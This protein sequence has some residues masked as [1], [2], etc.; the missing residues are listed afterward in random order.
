MTEPELNPTAA[1]MAFLLGTW[2]GQGKGDYPTIQPFDYSEE[3]AI[4][5]NGKPYLIYSHKTIHLGTGLPAHHEMGYFRPVADDRVE[6]VVVMPT[7][8]TEIEA[9]TL[10]GTTIEMSST[11]VGRAPT[12]KDVTKLE[13]TFT[14]DGDVMRYEV[15][16]A[17]VGQ[18]LQRHLIAELRRAD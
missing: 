2:R 10:D 5:H 13:R 9:G 8:I 18:P 7:G 17:A 6:L 11:G 14:V 12:A 15:K 4:T 1:R 16:M 3:I